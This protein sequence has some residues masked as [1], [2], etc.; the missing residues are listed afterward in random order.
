[1]C[2]AHP[3]LFGG[4]GDVNGFRG[5]ALGD[6]WQGD[7][8]N[9]HELHPG[10]GPGPNYLMFGVFDGQRALLFIGATPDEIW[11]LTGSDWST[12]TI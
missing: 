10:H 11:A 1:M 6:T 9:W 7:G 5:P 2:G 3:L 8:A 4:T 12:A